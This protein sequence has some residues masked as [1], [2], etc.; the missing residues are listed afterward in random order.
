VVVVTVV[1]A[2]TIGLDA[3]PAEAL[4]L[5]VDAAHRLG[6]VSY[7]DRAAGLVEVVVEFTE[8]PTS[9]VLMSLQGRS[10]GTTEVF[11]TVEPLSG[12]EAPP[13]AAV[14]ALVA[15]TLR[16]EDPSS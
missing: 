13:P 1:D 3:P 4:A 12:G 5:L 9:S 16:G 14:V 11:C 8:A 6:E 7:L 2:D 15:R 10:S